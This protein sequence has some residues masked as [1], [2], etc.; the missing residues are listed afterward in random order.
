M[1]YY[2][3]HC[4]KKCVP[5]VVVPIQPLAQCPAPAV[6]QKAQQLIQPAVQTVQQQVQQQM[7]Q[8]VAAATLGG[9]TNI[10]P[11]VLPAVNVQQPVAVQG[12]SDVL[13]TQ[14]AAGVAAGVQAAQQAQARQLC[15]NTQT[16]QVCLSV[17]NLD[18][19]VLQSQGPIANLLGQA[20]QAGLGALAG[21]QRVQQVLQS[22]PA[23]F[24]QQLVQNVP[25]VL[26][27]Q[28]QRLGERI[29]L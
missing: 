26:G 14:A 15:F 18:Q 24:R 4:K 28:V 25:Q 20:A 16:D 11:V 19:G 3:K 13:Q 23:E 17:S 21:Q 8:A 29:G 5:T 27:Q 22:L 7:Q 9:L 10:Q 2:R 1:A 6:A 12:G